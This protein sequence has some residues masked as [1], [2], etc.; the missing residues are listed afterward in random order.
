MNLRLPAVAA[1][2]AVGATLLLRPA[3]AGA[4]PDVFQGNVADAMVDSGGITAT[5][6][7]GELFYRQIILATP[8]HVGGVYGTTSRLP[9]YSNPITITFSQPVTNVSALITNL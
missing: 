3:P 6:G 8:G 9:G 5:Y 4:T 1:L 7:G 2:V